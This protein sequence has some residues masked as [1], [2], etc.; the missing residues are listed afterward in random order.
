MSKA[1]YNFYADYG[2]SGSIDG[3]FVAD[4]A[5]MDL[6]IESKIQVYYGD[7]LGKH[8]E[9]YGPVEQ[10]EITLKSNDPA[11]VA[12]FEKLKLSSGVN[13]FEHL[14]DSEDWEY[15]SGQWNN[16][17]TEEE[18]REPYDGEYLDADWQVIRDK[19]LAQKK[20]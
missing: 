20:G 13:P 1:I 6:L 3:T 2:R 4:V 16:W 8:S 11:E 15:M 5:K 9:V 7:I 12:L 14:E 19:F 10:S 17:D 18:V